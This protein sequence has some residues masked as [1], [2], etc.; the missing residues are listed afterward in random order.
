MVTLF[1]LCSEE[2]GEMTGVENLA[3]LYRLDLQA[4]CGRLQ[5]PIF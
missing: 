1:S 5:Q 4:G 2:L 3:D